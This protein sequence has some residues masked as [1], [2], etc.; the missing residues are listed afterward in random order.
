M[1][2]RSGNAA[3]VRICF[4]GK[5]VVCTYPARTLSLV[6]SEIRKP[7]NLISVATETLSRE[8]D[9][10]AVAMTVESLRHHNRYAVPLAF[11]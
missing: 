1:L 4:N 9:I 6:C 7:R 5:N 8:R 11:S 3:I 2:S 10:I